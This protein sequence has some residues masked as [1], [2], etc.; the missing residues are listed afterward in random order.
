MMKDWPSLQYVTMIFLLWTASGTLVSRRFG[1]NTLELHL[2][3]VEAQEISKIL[4]SSFSIPTF[5]QESSPS[6]T[7][8]PIRFGFVTSK[9]SPTIC[10]YRQG[11]FSAL[12]D[13]LLDSKV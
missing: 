1:K 13:A 3:P 8:L 6:S 4:S 9:S 12:L 10:T 2:M 5:C 7:A 11:D